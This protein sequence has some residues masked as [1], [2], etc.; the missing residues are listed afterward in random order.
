MLWGVLVTV[1]L[2]VVTTAVLSKVGPLDQ[3]R[4]RG[5]SAWPTATAGGLAIIAAVMA[6]MVTF[7]VLELPNPGP[8]LTVWVLLGACIIALLGAVDDV[9]DFPASVKLIVQVVVAGAFSIAAA[10]VEVLPLGPGFEI[11]LGPW[12]G[13]LGTALWLVVMVNAYNFMSQQNKFV[14]QGCPVVTK[15]KYNEFHF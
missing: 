8:G 1:L 2:T 15:S 4:E 3:P 9:M 11:D 14:R 10:R 5:L 13:G 12:V 7:V 6:G